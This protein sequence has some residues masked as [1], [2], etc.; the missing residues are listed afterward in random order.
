MFCVTSCEFEPLSA[1]LAKMPAFDR[2]MSR[3]K[4][5]NASLEEEEEEAS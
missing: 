1:S 5:N 2:S 4:K 3:R